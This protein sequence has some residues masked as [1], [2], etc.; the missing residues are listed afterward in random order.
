MT[1][2]HRLI[3]LS[4]VA[5]VCIAAIL[6]IALPVN[7]DEPEEWRAA[8][9]EE[10]W[11]MHICRVTFFSHIIER[12]TKDGDVTMVKVHCEDSRSFDAIRET[13]KRPFTF[14]ECTP[15]EKTVC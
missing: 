9:T 1:C 6:L 15:R 12:E 2:K 5:I 14:S 13:S 10:I 8:V 4:L 11:L 7:S 3:W